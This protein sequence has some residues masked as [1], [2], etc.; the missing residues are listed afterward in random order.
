M[1]RIYTLHG[2]GPYF[3]S[4]QEENKEQK[5]E[6]QEEKKE[7][8]K[9]TFEEIAA[10]I[11]KEQGLTEDPEKEDDKE[12]KEDENKEE[13]KEEEELNAEALDQ[14]KQLYKLL[15]DP[16]TAL[17]ALDI[18][19]KTAGF[20]LAEIKEVPKEEK[21][22]IIKSIKD[23]VK[24]RLGTKIP[25]LSDDL[26]AT[27]E[28]VIKEGIERGTKELKETV[29]QEK[30]ERLQKELLTTFETVVAS[31]D[32]VTEAVLKEVT[33][34]QQRKEVIPGEMV[35]DKYFKVCLALAAENLGVS[36]TKKGT[37]QQKSSE[38][39][40]AKQ[41]DPLQQLAA[42]KNLTHKEGLK[43]TQVKTMKDAID[44]AAEQIE[45]QFAGKT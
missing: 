10:R 4:K 30:Q 32:G 42:K 6:K 28:E 21:K 39:K 27:L 13:E 12:E 23:I 31:Y 40:P 35:P 41:V 20:K 11:A 22:E 34:I 3:D 36:I 43:T 18:L 15:N 17:Q 29:A 5:E 7:E 24:E 8:K 14:A 44:L 33:A 38:K 37:P 1:N 9:E 16:K 45:S 19:A 26:G 2:V 25:F